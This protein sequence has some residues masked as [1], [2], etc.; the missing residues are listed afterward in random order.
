MIQVTETL[1]ARRAYA[2]SVSLTG[3]RNRTHQSCPG[4]VYD[5]E[6][7]SP[8]TA[9]CAGKPRGHSGRVAA[10]TG[11]T[12]FRAL[13]NLLDVLRTECKARGLDAQQILRNAELVDYV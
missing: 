11:E 7:A 13:E 4:L 6:A 12:P 9:S 10:A 2:L 1:L 8:W 5:P 3:D